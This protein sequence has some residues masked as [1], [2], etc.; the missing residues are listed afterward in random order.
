MTLPCT[1]P[2][3]ASL[4]AVQSVINT[5]AAV[6]ASV[7]AS[8]MSLTTKL[9]FSAK[10]GAKCLPVLYHFFTPATD[11][12]VLGTNATTSA[13]AKSLRDATFEVLMDDAFAAFAQEDALDEEALNDRLADFSAA[14]LA[15]FE[16]S[17]D[18]GFNF[19]HYN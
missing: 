14:D 11:A 17:L 6:Q 7:D 9:E 4:P 12:C 8:P 2:T 10:S 15:A 19:D 18:K 1:S 3:P 16:D 13:A 5:V